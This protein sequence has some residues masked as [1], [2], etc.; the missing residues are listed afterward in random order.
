MAN[1]GPDG[2]QQV[3]DARLDAAIASA[4]SGKAM[5]SSLRREFSKDE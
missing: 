5:A 2:S 3:E 4:C 1:V